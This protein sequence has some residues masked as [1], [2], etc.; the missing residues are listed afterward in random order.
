[1]KKML[2]SKS[3]GLAGLTAALIVCQSTQAVTIDGSTIGPDG[4]ALSAEVIFTIAG[5][6]LNVQLI[7]TGAAVNNPADILTA[8]LF[9]L[10]SGVTLSP[11]SASLG[12][13]SSAF[14]GSIIN[15]VGEG[16]NFSSGISAHGDNAG[17]SAAGLGVFGQ[18]NFYGVP[19]TPLDGVGYGIANGF[20]NPNGGVTGAN[21]PI[22]SNE[23]D[24]TLGVTGPLDLATLES[25]VVFQWGT[26]LT[27]PS[28]PGGG[29]SVPDS[30]S[31][32]VMLGAAFVGTV[33]LRRKFCVA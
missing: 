9:N 26:S 17:I 13:G 8:V 31:T 5:A 11:T 15:N 12:A 23:V 25:S 24:F 28:A 20:N 22:I 18:P 2:C 1:M 14:F 19:V 4:A 21:G 33:W 30:G 7:N 29:S 27:E 32:L 10:P 16:W 6:N 3:L